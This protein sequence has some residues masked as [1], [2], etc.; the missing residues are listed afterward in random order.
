MI[1]EEAPQGRR[2]TTRKTVYDGDN[3]RCPSVTLTLH[4]EDGVRTEAGQ[5]VPKNLD[6]SVEKNYGTDFS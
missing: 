5:L 4:Y 2:D 3:R 1:K 6:E